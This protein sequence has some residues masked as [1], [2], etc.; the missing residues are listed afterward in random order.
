MGVHDIRSMIDK[1]APE[2]RAAG[3]SALYLFGSEARGEAGPDSDI[4]LAFDV[5]ADS[6]FSLL[7]Q[8][9][10]QVRLEEVLRRHVDFVSREGMRPKMRA[11]VEAEMVRLL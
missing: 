9:R 8:G 7:D 2:L 6:R 5:K 3:V 1:A 4:D 10:L 11:R